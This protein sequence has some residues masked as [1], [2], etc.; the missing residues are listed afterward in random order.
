MVMSAEFGLP[1]YKKKKK[2]TEAETKERR[3]EICEKCTYWDKAHCWCDYLLIMGKLRPC[4]G[5]LC[6]E[7]GVFKPKSKR[8]KINYN[9][10]GSHINKERS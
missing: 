6:V 7:E 5:S 9:F 10:N 8:A 3:L 2:E 4:H 1:I